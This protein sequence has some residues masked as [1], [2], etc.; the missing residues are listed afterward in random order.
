[1][2]LHPRVFQTCIITSDAFFDVSF[3]CSIGVNRDASEVAAAHT[4]GAL[5]VI[6]GDATQLPM[7]NSTA[8]V[9]L[10]VSSCLARVRS[11][12]T[13]TTHLVIP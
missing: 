2:K 7:A 12:L 1:M 6:Q 8:D 11:I 9:V 5:N 4:R 13:Y 10:A 3:E